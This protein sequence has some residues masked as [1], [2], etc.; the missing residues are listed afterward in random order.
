MPQDAL[1]GPGIPHQARAF[2]TLMHGEV[3]FCHLRLLIYINFLGRMR[4]YDIKSD[5]P[6]LYWWKGLCKDLGYWSTFF[7]IAY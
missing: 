4:C 3:S 1:T 7:E 2:N 5:S 6:C